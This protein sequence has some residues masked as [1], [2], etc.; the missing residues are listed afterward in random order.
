MT[1]SLLSVVIWLP[2][3]AGVA[4]LLTGGD[5]RAVLARWLAL[6]GALRAIEAGNIARGARVLCCLTGGTARPDG[7]AVPDGWTEADPGV[8]GEA[9][10]IGAR[11]GAPRRSP[12]A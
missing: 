9:L 2:I 4:V 11:T 5:R 12:P 3:L 1:N 8:A 6:A 7:L 10:R